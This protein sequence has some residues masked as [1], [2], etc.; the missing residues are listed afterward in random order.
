M[1]RKL[2][3]FSSLVLLSVSIIGCSIF[4]E[5]SNECKE[6]ASTDN[7]LKKASI[8]NSSDHNKKN[9]NNNQI[10]STNSK[11]NIINTNSL[12]NTIIEWFFKPNKEHKTPEVNTKLNFNLNDYD[13]IY[14]GNTNRKSKSLYLTFDEGY[15]NGYTSKILDILKEKKVNAV[16]FVTAPYIKSNPEL[17]KRIVNEGHIVGNHSKNHPS[18]PDKTSSQEDFDNEFLYVENEYKK[19][20]NKTMIKLFRPPMGKYSEKSLAMTKNLGYK[21]VFWSF[22]YQDWDQDKQPECNFAKEKITSNFHDGSIL[23]LHAVSK[24]NTKILSDVIDSAI[25]SGYKFKLLS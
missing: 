6:V 1:Q 17:I 10:N 13:A 2:I 24:T 23:L 25:N 11:N 8:D 7:P 19:L 4:K 21:S 14:N 16:F 20:T 15:E 3:Y 18:M 9:T 12:D 22:A 5:T